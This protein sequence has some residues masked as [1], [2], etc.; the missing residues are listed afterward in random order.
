MEIFLTFS[1]VLSLAF[2]EVPRTLEDARNER[3]RLVA[4]YLKT[5]TKE[6]GAI[7]LIGGQGEWEG[8]FVFHFM[9]FSHF[10]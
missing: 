9:W 10:Y 5:P 8:E 7:R 4:K 1:L 2:C 6:D 3:N